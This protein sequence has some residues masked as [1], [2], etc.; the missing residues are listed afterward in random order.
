M[1]T[2]ILNPPERMPPP[3]DDPF[4]IGRRPVFKR[5]ASGRNIVVDYIPMTEEDFLHPIEEDRFM[6][7]DPHILAC[8]YLMHAIA[9]GLRHRPAVR[10]FSDHRIDWQVPGIKP[11][12][13]DMAVFDNFPPK[14]DKFFGTLPVKDVGAVPVAVFEVTSESTRHV[15]LGPKFEEYAAVGIPYYM[16]VDLA[17]PNGLPDILAFRLVEGEYRDMQRYPDLGYLVA[18]LGMW[19]RVEGDRVVAA[20]EDQKDIPDSREMGMLID[21]EKVRADAEK[22]RA[23][24]MAAELAALKATLS[25]T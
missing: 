13:P 11:H 17:A 16:I 7:T 19:F 14:P 6:I 12:G 9:V 21:A 18:P 3:A 20:N 15:D 8:I 24:A 23:D 25:G 10:A 22:A 4:Y 2:G 5:D 1:S